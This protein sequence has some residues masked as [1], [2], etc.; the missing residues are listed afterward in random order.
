MGVVCNKNGGVDK[1]TE[2]FSRKICRK[3]N[4]EGRIILKITLKSIGL[5]GAAGFIWVRIGFN[6]DLL[7]TQ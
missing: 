4:M 6:G 1:C 7:W 2:K 3:K 5:K